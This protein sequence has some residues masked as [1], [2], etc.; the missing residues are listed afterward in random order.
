M[1]MYM[2][3]KNSEHLLC[4]YVLSHVACTC[5]FLCFRFHI[6]VDNIVYQEQISY[7]ICDSCMSIVMYIAEN[8]GKVIVQRSDYDMF[9]T[10]KQ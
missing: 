7:E 5:T 10:C 1:Y 8:K 4:R 3:Y 9:T 6:I 2:C